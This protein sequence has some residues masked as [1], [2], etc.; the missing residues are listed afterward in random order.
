M[1][2]AHS[3]ADDG[4]IPVEGA[5]L[6][7]FSAGAVATFVAVES[8]GTISGAAHR[9]HLSQPA[10]SRRL[11]QL[12]R[13]L[14]TPLFERLPAGLRLT[15]AGQAFLPHAERALAAE[16]DARRAVASRRHGPVGT[17]DL[18][19]V[20]SL[21]EPYLTAVLRAT[22][23]RHPGVELE[24][25]TATS[26]E[27]CHLVRRGGLTLGVSYAHPID[28]D[29]RV[30]EVDVERLVAVAGRHHPAAERRSGG[31]DIRHHR[32]LVFPERPDHPESSGTLVRRALERHQVPEARLRPIDSLSAQRSLLLA[33][34]GLALLPA[35]M[36]AE[37][38]A[39]GR[40]VPLTVP[41][42]AVEVP[43]TLCT[44][45]H[46]H[47]TVAA[48]TVIEL[49][50]AGTRRF[51]RPTPGPPTS[52]SGPGAPGIRSAGAPPCG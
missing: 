14:G 8:E 37:D 42:L 40:L 5:A 36:V 12:E 3:P 49:I 47:H 39:R 19:V 4:A 43:I 7:G 6:G 26:A 48:G 17:V 35:S 45:R 52:R 46:A 2:N 34:Y 23:E 16:A 24:V 9:L 50:R 29:L 28:P 44:R 41:T 33:G 11:Q 51:A 13:H 30:E 10:V 20:G 21:V 15:D 27:I 18:G 38:L 32:W 25:R 31:L 1:Q 22:L